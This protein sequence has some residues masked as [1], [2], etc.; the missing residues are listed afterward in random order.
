VNIPVITVN[1]IKTPERASWLIENDLVDFVALGRPQLADPAWAN[2]VKN[3]EQVN[4][5]SNCKPKCRWYE[6]SELC[7]A[8]QRLKTNE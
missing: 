6:D 8:V 2:H 4:I 3:R 5:C 7:P 1:E